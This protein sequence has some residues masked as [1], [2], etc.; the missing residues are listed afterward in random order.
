MVRRRQLESELAR[1]SEVRAD[2]RSPASLA[3]L[4]DALSNGA[5]VV[6]AKAAR[7]AGDHEIEGLAADLV[8]AVDRFLADPVRTDPGCKAKAAAAEALRR[9]GR[10]DGDVFLRGVRHVQ[11]EPTFGSREDTAAE[12]RGVCGLALAQM[13][14]PQALTELVHLLAD[15]EPL[16]RIAA[17]R[18]LGDTGRP[19]AVPLLR[20][21]GLIGDPD[22]GVLGEV[23]AALLHLDADDG[24][25]FV[26][27][28][29]HDPRE[30]IAEGA[31][32]ALGESRLDSAFEPLADWWRMPPPAAL[33]RTCLLALALLRRAEAF[34]LLLETVEKAP[35]RDALAALDALSTYRHDPR[36]AQRSREAARRRGASEL[37]IAVEAAFPA[38]DLSP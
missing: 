37:S 22:P 15:R 18:A 36:L 24:L 28:Y 27:G 12:F 8:A 25:G 10:E 17:A 38:D 9:I 3:H 26:A 30:A 5:S 1:L 21:K 13:G 14:H 16:A 7:I 29:L 2:P 32:L 11:M 34:D 23:L 31:A 4:R 6:A 35:L 20:F 33:R 19:E